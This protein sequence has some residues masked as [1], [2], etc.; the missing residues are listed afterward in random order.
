MVVTSIEICIDWHPVF[1][2]ALSRIKNRLHICH[3]RPCALEARFPSPAQSY[4]AADDR[5]QVDLAGAEQSQHPLPGGV[6]VA[7]RALQ[8]DGLAHQRVEAEI[9]RLRPPADLGDA[10]HWAA[11]APATA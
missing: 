2:L 7:E 10:G 1:C 5:L 11:P 6:G 8:G 9:Q 3:R 4:S